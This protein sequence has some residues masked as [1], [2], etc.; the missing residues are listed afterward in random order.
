MTDPNMA[1]FYNR[2]AKIQKARA[3]GYG[4]EAP[5]TLGRSYYAKPAPQRRSF[6]APVLFL[7]L[8]G[9]MLKGAMLN[10]IGSDLYKSRVQSLM[11]GQGLDRAGG[12]LMQ[13]DPVTVYLAGKIKLA[14]LAM[15]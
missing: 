11:A 13:A 7:V 8:C 3:K 2:V 4:F 10:Q 12:W 14:V 6:L 1:D 9:F 15:K 5:G